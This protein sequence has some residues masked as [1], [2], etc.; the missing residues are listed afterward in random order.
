MKKVKIIAI[1]LFSIFTINSFSQNENEEI[2]I[3][4]ADFPSFLKI[5]ANGLYNLVIKQGESQ[6]VVIESSE[7]YKEGVIKI[8]V[9]KETLKISSKSSKNSAN[10]TV[11]VTYKELKEI[12]ISEVV[13]LKN[14]GVLKRMK[15]VTGAMEARISE[16][17]VKAISCARSVCRKVN[18]AP[19][20]SAIIQFS[21][22]LQSVVR[23]ISRGNLM[24]T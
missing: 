4:P 7:Q 12:D 11:Y 13:N 9:N 24:A 2:N 18:R 5:E 15:R 6:K 21:R 3:T 17:T 23:K 19:I 16:A 8:E 1:F 10:Y 22:A 20:M 14:E